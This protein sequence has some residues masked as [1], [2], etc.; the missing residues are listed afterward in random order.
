MAL[1]RRDAVKKL[2]TGGLG[3]ATLPLWVD[4][5]GA[6]GRAHANEVHA[7]LAQNAAGA[8]SPKILSAHQNDTVIT[9]SELIIPQTETPGAKAV[10]VNRFIDSVLERGDDRSRAEFAAGLAGLDRK[11]QELHGKDFIALTPDQQTAL[12]TSIAPGPDGPIRDSPDAEFFQAMKSLTITGYYTSEV[13]LRQELGDDG[14]MFLLEF[15][16]CTHP[17]HQK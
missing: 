15:G 8:W 7:S 5:L 9:L 3:V 13:G 17:E 1:N 12:L 14:Q 2:M 6:F 16:G 11:S 4:E 10:F